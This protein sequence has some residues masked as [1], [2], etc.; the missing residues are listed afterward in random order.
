[1]IFH[2]QGSWPFVIPMT[3]KLRALDFTARIK[4]MSIMVNFRR[5]KAI[6]VHLRGLSMFLQ[7]NTQMARAVLLNT[8]SMFFSIQQKVAKIFADLSLNF[9][10]WYIIFKVAS[11]WCN[12]LI[13]I[14]ILI[15]CCVSSQILFKYFKRKW[16]TCTAK[17][18]YP[19]LKMQLS[20]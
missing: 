15:S 2:M 12:M 9:L 16:T 14:T 20:F 8:W 10:L 7:I 4:I 13:L 5:E 18:L 17:Q 19:S 6:F 1:M 3:E 11:F